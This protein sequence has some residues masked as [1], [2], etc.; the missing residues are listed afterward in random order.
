V[1]KTINDKVEILYINHT[2][3]YGEAL[4]LYPLNTQKKQRYGC[5]EKGEIGLGFVG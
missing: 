1:K 4:L 3:Y 2:T 5:G